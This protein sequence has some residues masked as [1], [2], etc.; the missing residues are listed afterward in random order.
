[1][2]RWVDK[3]PSDTAVVYAYDL[4]DTMAAADTLASATWSVSPVGL[5]VQDLASDGKFAKCALTGG[6][7]GVTYVL[8]VTFVTGTGQTM[9]RNVMVKVR[10][11]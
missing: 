4:T 1:M 3:D 9:Q 2:N 8:T 5:T 11:Q 7:A 6:T 10:Q